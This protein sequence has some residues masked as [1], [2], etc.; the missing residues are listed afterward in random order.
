MFAVWIFQIACM[1]EELQKIADRQRR[2][3]Q[4]VEDV[5]GALQSLSGM[6]EV[7]GTLRQKK[8]ELE[9]QQERLRELAC[10]LENLRLRYEHAEQR[11][12]GNSKE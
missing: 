2:A 10:G 11:I 5:I 7:I 4:D 6:G 12:V 8:E 3:L 9:V 1:G